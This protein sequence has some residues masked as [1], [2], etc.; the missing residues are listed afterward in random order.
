VV[1][2]VADRVLGLDGGEEVGGDKL[3]TL[4]NELG[5]RGRRLVGGCGRTRSSTDL[6]E[7]VLAWGSEN[8][9]S[10]G[11]ARESRPAHRWYRFVPR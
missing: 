2:A 9:I 1:Q 11:A 6:V 10:E 7:G 8:E 4:M 3:G 5:R